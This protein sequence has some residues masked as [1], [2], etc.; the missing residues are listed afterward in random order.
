MIPPKRL[1]QLG[2]LDHLLRHG[3]HDLA[4]TGIVA[5]ATSKN[6]CNKRSRHRDHSKPKR[7]HETIT[8]TSLDNGISTGLVRL[9]VSVADNNSA[10]CQPPPSLSTRRRCRN[11]RKQRIEGSRAETDMSVGYCHLQCTTLC[12]PTLPMPLA[13]T[14]ATRPPC[15]MMCSMARGYS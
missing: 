3:I 10:Q 2:H 14:T 6:S 12:P 4:V 8:P 7:S 9:N 11:I 13:A 1:Q 5:P 15:I